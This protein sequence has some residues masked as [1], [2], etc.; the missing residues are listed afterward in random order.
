MDATCVPDDQAHE[1][2]MKVNYDYCMVACILN[3]C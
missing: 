3:S 2:I 1:L